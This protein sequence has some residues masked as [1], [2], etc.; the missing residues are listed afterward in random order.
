MLTWLG[1]INGKCYHIWQHHGSYGYG[2]RFANIFADAPAY[3]MAPWKSHSMRGEVPRQRFESVSG[4]IEE[5]GPLS[6]SFLKQKSRRSPV[7]PWLFQ[8]YLSMN[9]IWLVV[10]GTFG[11]F[12]H[13]LGIIPTDF[14]SI[15]FQRGRV[16]TTNQWWFGG[17][18]GDTPILG[19]QHVEF[20]MFWG[21]HIIHEVGNPHW[22]S[23]NNGM[24]TAQLCSADE[25][26]QKSLSEV[27]STTR[28]NQH[29]VIN[30][31]N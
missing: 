23:T 9:L 20:P 18:N 15:I 26:Q 17:K 27:A 14:H 19:T 31:I 30:R 11:L 16:K 7:V 8:Y 13:I 3:S 6:A 4:S 10:T 25:I 28:N 22:P 29:S 24:N 12:F 2:I 5:A 1:Y 21:I